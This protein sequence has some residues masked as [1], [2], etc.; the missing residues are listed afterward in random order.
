MPDTNNM[1]YFE[2][3]YIDPITGPE[4]Y[5]QNLTEFFELP[6][7][8]EENLIWY[9]YSL[10]LT[11]YSATMAEVFYIAFRYVGPNGGQGA[12]TYYV[13]NVSWGADVAEGGR[14]VR[15]ETANA[16]R[17]EKLLRNGQIVIRRDG[18]EY[19]VLGI[20]VSR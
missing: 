15:S 2:V 11:P 3:Y 14:E 9:T 1:A 17:S 18:V 10:D 16:V 6:A 19:T 12:V 13:D 5:F 4:P 7:T 8:S 20:P